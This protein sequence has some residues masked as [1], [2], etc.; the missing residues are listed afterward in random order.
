M[1]VVEISCCAFAKYFSVLN[2]FSHLSHQLHLTSGLALHLPCGPLAAA[3]DWG[4]SIQQ[5]AACWS[6]MLLIGG[7]SEMATISKGRKK[8]WRGWREWR[9]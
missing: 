8:S 4:Q 5:S 9:W 3:D 6:I 1:L 2:L 7:M